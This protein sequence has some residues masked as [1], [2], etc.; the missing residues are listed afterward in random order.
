MYHIGLPVAFIYGAIWPYLFA[1][2][3][4]EPF[5]EL[6]FELTLILAPLLDP[7]SL[8]Q[9]IQPLSFIRA[10]IECTHV[11]SVP[12]GLVSDPLPLIGVTNCVNEGPV[13][14]RSPVN[15]VTLVRR[16]IWPTH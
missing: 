11:L 15:P 5:E 8:L 3:L 10:P 12:T 6:T 4:F 14:L 13:A 9:I 1:D 2:T 16:S 7:M